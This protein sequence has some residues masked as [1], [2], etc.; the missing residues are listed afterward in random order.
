[1]VLL[2]VGCFENW[3][4]F[5]D[6]CWI[7]RGCG[8]RRGGGEEE[9]GGE[10]RCELHVDGGVLIQYPPPPI[11]RRVDVLF[12]ALVGMLSNHRKDMERKPSRTVSIDPS[13][14]QWPRDTSVDW[15]SS[16]NQIVILAAALC[17]P[18]CQEI[19]DADGPRS[20][21][22]VILA[23]VPWSSVNDKCHIE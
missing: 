2:C 6:G 22:Q 12:A 11:T 3:I 7:G 19:L 20:N 17:K 10:E 23:G 5:W 16:H 4:G 13:K 18:T 9:S 21:N 14:A 1:M 8:E 15:P